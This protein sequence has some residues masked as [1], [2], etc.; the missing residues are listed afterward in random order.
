MKRSEIKIGKAYYYEPGRDW[1]TPAYSNGGGQKA[2]ALDVSIPGG[3]VLVEVRHSPQWASEPFTTLHTVPPAHLRGPWEETRARV[4]EFVRQRDERRKQ[5][6]TAGATLAGLAAAAYRRAVD[7]GFDPRIGGRMDP[8]GVWLPASAVQRLLDA[9][10]A[11]GS[12][13]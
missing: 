5:E 3:K 9:Y 1:A 8:G 2:F 12:Q 7:L 11:G 10:E 13:R 6:E 4:A